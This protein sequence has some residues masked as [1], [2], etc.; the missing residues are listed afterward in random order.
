MDGRIS[1]IE[2][3]YIEFE[4]QY[5]K[6]SVENILFQRGVKTTIQILSDKG[7]FDNFQKADKFGE[8]CLFTARLRGDLEKVNEH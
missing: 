7:L 2:K 4:L 3:N 5:N 1:Y 6:Q 8:D